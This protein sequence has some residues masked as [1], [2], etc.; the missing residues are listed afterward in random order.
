MEVK[1]R[2]ELSTGNFSEWLFRPVTRVSAFDRGS[3]QQHQ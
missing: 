3:Q 1:G 2:I